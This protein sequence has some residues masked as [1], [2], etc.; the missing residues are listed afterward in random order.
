MTSKLTVISLRPFSHADSQE[1]I[2][3]KSSNSEAFLSWNIP[4]TLGNLPL[5]LSIYSSLLAVSSKS[6]VNKRLTGCC[7]ENLL[8]ASDW[9]NIEERFG[10]RFRVRRLKGVAICTHKC[11]QDQPLTVLLLA[12]LCVVENENIPW[13]VVKS[14]ANRKTVLLFSENHFLLWENSLFAGLLGVAD[15]LFSEHGQKK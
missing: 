13:E 15:Y 14:S 12:K 10:D 5:C 7:S 3:L 6:R 11:M 9:W 8:S 4:N 1:L 2:L